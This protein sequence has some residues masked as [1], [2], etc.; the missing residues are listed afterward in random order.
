MYC[1]EKDKL[2]KQRENEERELFRKERLRLIQ[3]RQRN[4]EPIDK[5][6]SSD[7]L[8]AESISG[9]KRGMFSEPQRPTKKRL[10]VVKKK[11]ETED[12]IGLEEQEQTKEIKEEQCKTQKNNENAGKEDKCSLNGKN[13]RV[14]VATRR[15]HTF[16]NRTTSDKCVALCC[17]AAA[18]CCCLA[19]LADYESSDDEATGDD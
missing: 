12:N 17:C 11:G 9:V 6:N 1:R 18:L 14:S 13:L 19:V 4:V 16:P 7:A 3:E 15:K 10:V 5:V 8:D 2:M